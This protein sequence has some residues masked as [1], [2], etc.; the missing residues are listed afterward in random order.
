MGTIIQD[1]R[2]ALR[3]LSSNPAFAMIALLVLALGIGAS[4]AIFSVVNAVLIQPLAYPDSDRLAQVGRQLPLGF[5]SA[6]SPAQFL[7]YRDHNESFTGMATYDGR[8]G[9]MNLTGGETPERLPSRRVSTGFFDVLQVQP[10]LGRGFLPEDGAQGAE[11][12]AVITHGLWQRRFGGDPEI[13]GRPIRLSGEN[14]TVVGIVKH[15]FHPAIAAD[16]WTPLILDPNDRSAVFYI[17]ARMKPGVTFQSA[18]AD[19]DGVIEEFRRERPDFALPS[20]A[21]VVRPFFNQIVGDISSVLMILLGA[22][23]AVLLIACAN[24]ANLLLARATTRYREIAVRTALGASRA[25]VIRQLLT[26]SGLLALMGGLLGLVIAHLAIRIMLWLKPSN[27]PRL[28]EVAIDTW[29]LGFAI[30]VTVATGILFGLFPAFQA[31]KLDLQEAMKEGGTRLSAGGR[32]GMIRSGLMVAEVTLAL[33]PL[34]IASLLIHSFL[35]LTELD[36]GFDYRNVLT[37]KMSPSGV[38]GLTTEKATIFRRQAIERIEALPGI[39]AAATISTLPLEHG[40]MQ[41]FDVAGRPPPDPNE[42]TGRAQWRLISPDYFRA[43]G[44]PLLRGRAFND[45]DT[46]DSPPVFIINNALAQQYFRGEDPVGQGLATGA[47]NS[48]SPP[49]EIVGVV[50]DI[51]EIALHL[52]P[53]PTLYSPATQA[54][55]GL[56][57]FLGKILP[58]CW[59]V[60]TSGNPFQYSAA[61][62]QEILAVDSDQPVSSVRTMEQVM[63]ES[64]AQRQFNTLLLT[65]FAGLAVLLAAIG[66]Y[67]V[68][69]YS[70]AQRIHEIGIRIAIGAGRAETFRLILL[71]GLKLALIGVIAGLGIAY[72]ATRLVSAML[73]EVSA[74]DPLIFGLMALLLIVVAA[75]ACYVPASRAMRVDPIVALRYE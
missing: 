48:E 28:D 3:T 43:M 63:S 53:T 13:I 61:I 1:L 18:Q 4:T 50:G 23:G 67:G 29:V 12:V 17:V 37:M 71:Q 66:I 70:V 56:T 8:G 11:K 27:L 34:I 5:S 45:Q 58:T 6:L 21:P 30:M 26:E 49:I 55:D 62:Q 14:F 59:L 60:R 47:P 10:H 51:K 22:V 69:S 9:G 25:R 64:V 33:V 41:F 24:V 65:L 20:E 40:L 36:P 57:S 31:S 19:M 35:K 73:F 15:S 75:F 46:P 2:Y 72:F 74:T 52:D 44:I 54:D 32:R 68:M 16:V 38:E 39:E 7:F 42:R